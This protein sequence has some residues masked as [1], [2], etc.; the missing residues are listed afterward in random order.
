MTQATVTGRDPS[1][2]SGEMPTADK[3]REYLTSTAL[4]VGSLVFLDTADATG[5]TIKAVGSATAQAQMCAVGVYT[6]KGGSGAQTT[7]TGLSGK[8]AAVGDRVR[9]VK[10]GVVS[11]LTTPSTTGTT[12]V[13][14]IGQTFMV[15]STYTG[16][17]MDATA[18]TK[19]GANGGVLW[20]TVNWVTV[21]TAYVAKVRIFCE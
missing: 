17:M 2:T 20:T 5:N 3:T 11:V 7:V 16:M 9:I 21:G 6:G 13:L 14:T 18:G 4:S 12:T 1:A 10:V 15:G 8:D 19:V